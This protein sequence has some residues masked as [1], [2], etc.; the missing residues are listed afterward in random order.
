MN[1]SNFTIFYFTGTGNSRYIA[2]KISAV[3]GGE[4]VD[5]KPKFKTNDFSPVTAEENI[6]FVTPTYCWQIPHIVRDWIKRVSFT[7][8]KRAWFVMDCGSGIGNAAKCNKELCEEKGFAYM[9]TAKIVM[10]ENYIAMFNAP[11]KAEAAEIIRKAEPSIEAAAEAIYSGAELKA[12]KVLPHEKLISGP[13]NPLFYKHSV[14][15]KPFK[16]GKGCIGCGKCASLC[17][18]NSI[19]IKNGKPVWGDNCTHCMACISYCPT[20]AIEY[21]RKSK[22]KARYHCD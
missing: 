1:K 17:P 12:P 2:R 9:G 7:G 11:E 22:G 5:L 3:T 13:F 6:V 16:V 4:L 8:V 20:Q 10:P 19:I 15:S 21:G 18:T 14:T